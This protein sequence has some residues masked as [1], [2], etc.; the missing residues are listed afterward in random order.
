MKKIAFDVVPATMDDAESIARFQVDMAR[1]SEGMTLDMETVLNGVTEGLKDP[2]KGL[3]L[4][5]RNGRGEP[6][7]SLMVTKEWSDGH[8]KWY[9]WLQSVY[10]KP[11]YR[12]H[13]VFT[14]MY[15]TV[16]AM[17][18]EAQAASLRLYV[19]AANSRAW[20]VYSA[21]GMMQSHYLLYEDDLDDSQMLPF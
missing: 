6:I 9:W 18:K 15:T 12:R 8:C 5:A 11:R 7:A 13:G 4:V 20:E 19:D 2:N 1:E 17:A 3:Y 14:N 16:K 10:V 21:L